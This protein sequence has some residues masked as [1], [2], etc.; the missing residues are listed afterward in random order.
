MKSVPIQ[1]LYEL[2]TTAG[3]GHFLPLIRSTGLPD[4]SGWPAT[5]SNEPYALVWERVRIR[6]RHAGP[7]DEE[8]ES[9][10]EILK[11]WRIIS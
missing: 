10:E 11:N 5:E 4:A 2:V 1:L 9:G 7:T 6:R 8:T 3:P